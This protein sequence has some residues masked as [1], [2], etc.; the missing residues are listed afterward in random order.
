M[1]TLESMVNGLM[2]HGLG[3]RAAT[4]LML[5]AKAWSL[6]FLPNAEAA[7]GP[8]LAHVLIPTLRHRTHLVFDWETAYLEIKK[9][10]E[11]NKMLET[12]LADFALACAP[13][14]NEYHRTFQAELM[15]VLDGDGGGS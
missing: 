12:M 10:V 13:R 6:L 9:T 8:C 5:G 7:E 2:T 4:A 11:P 1:K 14:K 3:P 15:K